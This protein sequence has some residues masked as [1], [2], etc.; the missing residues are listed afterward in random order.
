MADFHVMAGTDKTLSLPAVRKIST[1][2]VIDALGRGLD[3]FWQK[4][5]HYAFLC[6]IYPLVGWC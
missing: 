2:D 4:P 3:D 1:S 6:L 5:S